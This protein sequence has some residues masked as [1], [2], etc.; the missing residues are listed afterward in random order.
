[1]VLTMFELSGK[2]ALSQQVVQSKHGDEAEFVGSVQLT[3]FAAGILSALMILLADLPLAHIVSS[4]QCFPS[5]MA[6][7]VIPLINGLSSLDVYRLSRQMNFGPLV[8]TEIV[9]QV[10]MT[11]A[12][13]PLAVFYKDYR[14]VL[15]L[16]LAK[17]VLAAG[18]THL[19]A[20]RRFSLRLDQRWFQESLKF[21]WPLLVTGFIQFGNV[22]GDSMIVA[23]A[24]PLAQLGAYSVAMTMAMAPGL[25]ILRISLSMGLP[26]LSAVQSDPLQL[27]V[28]YRLFTQIMALVGSFTTLGMLF[29]GEQ[30]VVLLF[31][32]KYAG[33]GALACVL[34]AAQ[35]L[36]VLRGAP[37]IAAMARGDTVNNLVSSLWRLSGLGVACIVGLLK[38]SL[39][40]FAAA[41]FIG[42]AIA[43][44]VTVSRLSSK[45]SLAP[46]LTL[47]PGFL[48]AICVLSAVVIKWAF[49]IGPD[50]LFNWLLLPVAILLTASVFLI[51]FPELRASTSDFVCHFKLRARKPES[52]ECVPATGTMAAAAK[53]ETKV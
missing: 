35:A 2:M 24:Y 12:S 27:T 28:R 19:L 40:W 52:A 16:V 39:T 44:W 4:P 1:M 9:P 36:R 29:C 51:G 42:E 20:E 41:G 5:I 38:C 8:M 21:G 25:T 14:A 13:W 47:L 37:V 3:Q 33:I 43:L 45:H 7:A 32:A 18:M 23:T 46:R 26:L 15:V 6:L 11:L 30:V 49:A 50:S 34:T 53:C 22:Q 10:I 17:G 48:G 31:G